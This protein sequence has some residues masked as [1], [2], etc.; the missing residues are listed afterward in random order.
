MTGKP[1]IGSRLLEASAFVLF[2]IWRPNSGLSNFFFG[3]SRHLFTYLRSEPLYFKLTKNVI[4]KYLLCPL[5]C[6]LTAIALPLRVDLLVKSTIR[7]AMITQ[8][9]VLFNQVI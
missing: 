6:T 4:Y 8:L 1:S 2:L 9:K 3:I 5:S 7:S